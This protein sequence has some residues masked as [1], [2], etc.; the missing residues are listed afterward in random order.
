VFVV[1]DTDPGR[2]LDLRDV[3][4]GRRFHV[5]EQAASQTLKRA[6]LH[7]TSVVTVGGDS[8][9]IGGAPVIVPPDWHVS[10]IGW[11]DRVLRRKAITRSDLA[12]AQV[13]IRDLYFQVAAS[14]SSAALPTLRNTDGDDIEL[15]T[16]V[17]DVAVPVAEAFER[18]RPLAVVD[19]DAFI[20]DVVT[21]G[22]G[23]VTAATINWSKAGNRKQK[24]W[25]NTT[26]GTLRLEP[27]R[28]TA[29]VNSARRADRLIREVTRRLGKAGVTLASRSVVDLEHRLQEDRQRPGRRRSRCADPEA[30]RPPELVE[31]EAAL[32]RQYA[33]EWLDTRVPA[34]GNRTPRQ[35]VR[36]RGG[37][38]RVEALLASFERHDHDRGALDAATFA[39]MRRELGLS[40]SDE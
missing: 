4:T 26:L 2:S 27:G 29:D 40:G 1:E 13:E 22:A 35:A 36:T 34:L 15:T 21:D 24:S 19:D 6:D 5:L 30:D 20:D 25:T 39:A 7:F 14:L 37:R 23:A 17:F 12:K 10:V 28:L 38:E 9:M 31:M 18:L 16:L 3:L 8:I 11:R 33:L 32:R